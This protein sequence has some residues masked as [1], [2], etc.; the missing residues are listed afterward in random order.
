MSRSRP[1]GAR[2]APQCW[3]RHVLWKDRGCVRTVPSLKEGVSQLVSPL[4]GSA[5]FPTLPGAC[6]PGSNQSR[7]CAAVLLSSRPLAQRKN[8]YD[9]VSYGT[10]IGFP[11]LPS[12][13]AGMFS[14][15]EPGLRRTE[16]PSYPGMPAAS[17]LCSQCG[18][19][20]KVAGWDSGAGSWN[21]PSHGGISF[22]VCN[23]RVC[24]D[25]YRYAD[26]SGLIS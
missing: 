22:V 21:V 1:G 24:E 12:A 25:S 7:R 15:L 14:P 16:N 9:T 18:L 6:A 13:D 17:F 3:P 8:G 10:R 20:C 26:F 2:S 19:R 23:C 5:V 4:R 11:L